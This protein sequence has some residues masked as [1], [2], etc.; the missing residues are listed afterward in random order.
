M[1]LISV[2]KEKLFDIM[3]LFICTGGEYDN[4]HY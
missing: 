2:K 4:N 3:C 1:V